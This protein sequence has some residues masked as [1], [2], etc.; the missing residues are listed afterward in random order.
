MNKSNYALEVLINGRPAKE[1]YKDG[2]AFIE[3]R[4]GTQ[5]T[6]KFRNNSG[7][8]V[9]AVFSVDGIEVIEGK[10]ASEYQGGYIID[11]Y[12]SI[13]VKGYRIDEDSV[14]AFRFAKTHKS[15]SNTVGGAS[16]NEERQVTEYVKTTH[17]NGVIGVRVFE[18]KAKTLNL[19]QNS[20]HINV[21]G[22]Y[23]IP[24]VYS[25]MS[26]LNNQVLISGW[27]GLSQHDT[28]SVITSDAGSNSI[29]L[30]TNGD[31]SNQRLTGSRVLYSTVGITTGPAETYACAAVTSKINT[32]APDFNLGT[33]WGEKVEDRVKEIHFNKS[34]VFEDIEIYYDSR[35]GLSAYGIDFSATKQYAKWPAAFGE[36]RKFCKM[37]EGYNG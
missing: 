8:R 23:I 33:T 35:E 32:P 4:E 28:S 27:C 15:Y 25:G 24:A 7:K 13:E 22:G 9:L 21:T 30:V 31:S 36:K 29:N 20:G 14:A 5:Y 16:F 37:P 19:G 2:R 1:Y 3:G 17:N 34:D 10:V 6:L 26:L 11:P 18:E 12:S